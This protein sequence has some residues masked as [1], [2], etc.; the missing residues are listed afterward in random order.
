MNTKTFIEDHAIGIDHVDF[1][2]GFI[3]AGLRVK[4]IERYP[5]SVEP[6]L[7]RI[8]IR[9]SKGWFKILSRLKWNHVAELEREA[10]EGREEGGASEAWWWR[11]LP[12][13]EGGVL[14]LLRKIAPSAE[15]RYFDGSVAC[16]DAITPR[17]DLSFLFTLKEGEQG[18]G[19]DFFIR[20]RLVRH[21]RY[22]ISSL[23]PCAPPE[24]LQVEGEAL[25]ALL[26]KQFGKEFRQDS[27]HW[28]SKVRVELVRF[29]ERKA[30]DLRRIDRL[31]R[32]RRTFYRPNDE[33]EDHLLA[34][35]GAA[36]FRHFENTVAIDVLT[37][38]I[39]WSSSVRSEWIDR[40]VGISDAL[41]SLN[42]NG[43]PLVVR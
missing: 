31:S 33:W 41:E 3:F 24:P 16:L 9:K 32:K 27:R 17:S 21:R 26:Q 20:G 34:R 37:H 43:R 28:A 6:G 7:W 23:P 5:D 30:E 8:T 18:V 4:K 25:L 35:D 29:L 19:I 15:L 11:S 12:E 39:D 1:A 2:I 10:A 40:L 36:L 14:S 13:T 38:A 22:A 42:R